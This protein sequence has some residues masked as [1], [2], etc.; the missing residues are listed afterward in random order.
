MLKIRPTFSSSR[1]GNFFSHEGSSSGLW[2]LMVIFLIPANSSENFLANFQE[3]Y[4]FVMS[5]QFQCQK[6]NLREY[7]D[8]YLH[9]EQWTTLSYVFSELVRQSHISALAQKKHFDNIKG[10]LERIGEKVWASD[11]IFMPWIKIK[12]WIQ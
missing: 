4:Q 8:E 3:K 9:M 7:W 2:R 12:N 1:N 5:R 11:R 6:W 10:A